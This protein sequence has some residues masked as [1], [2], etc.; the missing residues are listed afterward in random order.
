MNYK[1]MK[2]AIEC[3][4]TKATYLVIGVL[5]LSWAIN[6]QAKENNTKLT[7]EVSRGFAAQK[8]VTVDVSNKYGQVIINTWKQD[9]VKI[10]VVITAYG[11]RDDLVE[12]A[13]KRVDLDFRQSGN[14]ITAE[15]V[16]DRKSGSLKE[17]FNSVGDYSKALLSKNKLEVDYQIYMPE[18]ANI[19][20]DNKFGDVYLEEVFGKSKIVVSHGNLRAYRLHGFARIDVSFGDANLKYIKEGELLLKVAEADIT[21]A[22][23]VNI[24]GNS[25]KVFIKEA[26]EL[27]VDC[28]HDKLTI[29][30]VEMIRGRG[31][32][33]DVKINTMHVLTDLELSYGQVRI[34]EALDGFNQIS[35]NG[36]ST[37]IEVNLHG[38]AYVNADITAVDDK[39]TMPISQNH[40]KREAKDDRGK[41]VNV[42]GYLG[43]DKG[44]E[45]RL[46]IDADGG[47]TQIH[48][49]PLDPGNE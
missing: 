21:Q 42:S 34:N 45:S 15:T 47:D 6:L 35:I 22:D 39:L 41:V 14:F 12:K 13:L 28:R 10:E 1:V 31:S 3:L 48:F 33:S 27:G 25:S 36:K 7:K 30:S 44:T 8:D 2:K 38:N 46:Y 26:K 32:F 43:A 11:K 19:Y 9:S 4:P 20:I 16:L 5:C 37:D 49:N 18:T 29:E 24:K 40:T 17:F 23:A